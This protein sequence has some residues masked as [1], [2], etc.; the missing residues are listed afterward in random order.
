VLVI[1][2]SV[3]WGVC[4]MEPQLDRGFDLKLL[5]QDCGKYK[6]FLNKVESKVD[7]LKSSGEEEFFRTVKRKCRSIRVE[8]RELVEK[9]LPRYKKELEDE[10]GFKAIMAIGHGFST[11]FVA[12][13]LFNW[14]VCSA[15]SIGC[16]G[17]LLE[18]VIEAMTDFQINNTKEIKSVFGIRSGFSQVAERAGNVYER[19]LIKEFRSKINSARSDGIYTDL[20][21]KTHEL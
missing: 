9:K 7:S 4:G 11:G 6:V 8:S 21:I 15:L 17:A 12:T 10:G 13:R 19:V 3:A 14:N 20:I 18:L 1:A 2:L 16:V 5:E